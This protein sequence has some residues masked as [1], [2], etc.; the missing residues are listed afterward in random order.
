MPE[1]HINRISIVAVLVLSVIGYSPIGLLG[2]ALDTNAFAQPFR[3]LVLGISII[4]IITKLRAIPVALMLFFVMYGIRLV[5]D[6]YIG[7]PGDPDIAMIFFFGTVMVPAIAMCTYRPGEVN[8]RMV[9]WCMFILAAGTCIGSLVGLLGEY[10]MAG[11]ELDRLGNERLN[12]IT[13]GHTAVTAI[14][15]ALILF[16][17][18]SRFN[19]VL[20]VGASGAAL[21]TLAG[22]A[23]RGPLLAL[24]ACLLLYSVLTRRVWLPL[25]LLLA[26]AAIFA[27]ETSM[28]RIRF[29]FLLYGTKDMDSAASERLDYQG[30]S[31]EQFLEKPILG[32]GMAEQNTGLY[33]HNMFIE[34]FMALGIVGGIVHAF[35]L[36]ALL[37]G[38][39]AMLV[40]KQYVAPLLLLQ[41]FVGAQTSG[42]INGNAPYWVLVAVVTTYGQWRPKT[43]L[44]D[45]WRT[46]RGRGVPRLG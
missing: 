33:P 3:A 44:A 21:W 19:K 32:S 11:N 9:A 35:V 25:L 8:W 43:K 38:A 17:G 46:Y 40:D 28:L 12:T 2:S 1:H 30:M 36:V 20:L 34:T 6:F 4:V 22:S 45:W 41:Y 23:A 18:A 29:E 27:D 16:D 10:D 39:V 5:Y 37:R 31:W 15:C 7:A 26:V 13:L 14:I 24:A 42:N